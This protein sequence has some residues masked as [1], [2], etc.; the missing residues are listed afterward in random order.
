MCIRDSPLTAYTIL[1]AIDLD[2]DD[3]IDIEEFSIALNGIKLEESGEE[4]VDSQ[5]SPKKYK[6]PIPQIKADLSLS[7][8][9]A[10]CSI[11]LTFALLY[12][13]LAV[14]SI[15]VDAVEESTTLR[16]VE[17]S[18]ALNMD[19][20]RFDSNWNFITGDFTTGHDMGTDFV[21]NEHDGRTKWSGN[22]YSTSHSSMYGGYFSISPLGI[23][24]PYPWLILLVVSIG[25]SLIHISEPTRPY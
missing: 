2:D 15:W 12:Y 8:V 19:T 9:I 17:A 7:S 4:L 14:L 1:K 16:C 6:W 5:Q 24:G 23:D 21:Y 22:F 3:S 11:I 18:P 20:C 25:L 10:T 13:S